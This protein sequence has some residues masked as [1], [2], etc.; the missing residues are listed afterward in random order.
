[1]YGRELNGMGG[2]LDDHGCTWAD[3]V[4]TAGMH[5]PGMKAKSAVPVH[6]SHKFFSS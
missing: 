1:M 3:V 4:E 5:T 2:M 6:V